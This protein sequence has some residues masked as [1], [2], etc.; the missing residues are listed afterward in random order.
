MIK[1]NWPKQ[2]YYANIQ[3][4]QHFPSSQTKPKKPIFEINQ[5]NTIPSTPTLA[6]R[7]PPE[8]HSTQNS[9]QTGRT[10][11]ACSGSLVL[12]PG[13]NWIWEKGSEKKMLKWRREEK[14]ERDAED[15]VVHRFCIIR[16]SDDVIWWLEWA[17]HSLFRYRVLTCPATSTI[18]WLRVEKLFKPDDN[19]I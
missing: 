10:R 8:T 13:W 15:E 18:N 11:R 4:L 17:R 9:T 3:K 12:R 16:P 6:I 5:P 1:E 19:G 7:K 14:S 2:F